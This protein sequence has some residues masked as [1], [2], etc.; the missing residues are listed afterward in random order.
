MP[1]SRRWLLAILLGALGSCD[2]G[3]VGVGQQCASSEECAAGLVCDFGRM[4]HSCQQTDS[5]TRDLSVRI[6]DG[7]VPDLT[8]LADP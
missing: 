7:A 5:L 4:P 8:G 2:S 3:P 1:I 6:M